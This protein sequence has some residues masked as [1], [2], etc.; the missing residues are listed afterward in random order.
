MVFSEYPVLNFLTIPVLCQI[1]PNQPGI[2]FHTK[3]TLPGQTNSP[4]AELPEAYSFLPT[5]HPRELIF[6]QA[7]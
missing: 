7:K 4:P 2:K 5:R 1:F 6:R 3:K